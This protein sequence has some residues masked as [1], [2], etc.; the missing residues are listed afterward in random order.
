MAKE[1]SGGG[2]V[3]KGRKSTVKVHRTGKERRGEEQE[4]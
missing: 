3:G 4:L 1:R 2:G